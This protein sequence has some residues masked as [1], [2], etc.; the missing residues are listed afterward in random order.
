MSMDFT[1]FRRKL[2]AEPRSSDPDLVAARD[3]SPE[4]REAALRAELFEDKLERAFDLPAPEELLTGLQ[5]IPARKN[6]LRKGWPLALAASLLVAV[7]AAGVNWQ[8]N[9]GWDSVQEYVMDHYRHD[10]VK[11]LEQSQARH[12]GDVHSILAEFDVDATPELA[13][14]VNVIK[15]C[16]TPEGKGVHMVLNTENGPI[17]V[18]YMPGTHVTDREMLAFDDHEALLVDLASGAAAIIG[19]ESQ[20][21]ED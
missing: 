3:S 14:I 21:V 15:F 5:S 13:N 4:H 20:S 12:F 17:T 11:V 19:A 10:G 2:G 6:T 7:G 16:P 1:E 9:R 18:I 8:M